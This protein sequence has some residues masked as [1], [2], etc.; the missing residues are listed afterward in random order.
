MS[1]TTQTATVQQAS[2]ADTSGRAFW[3]GELSTTPKD[4]PPFRWYGTRAVLV[5][6]LRA[7]GYEIT[8]TGAA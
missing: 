6:F 3:T 8:F 4:W 2:E 5:S 7:K 1:E